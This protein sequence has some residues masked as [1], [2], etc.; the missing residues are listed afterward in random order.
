MLCVLGAS[1]HACAPHAPAPACARTSAVP[2]SAQ[3]FTA[4]RYAQ[5]RLKQSNTQT[6]TVYNAQRN[7]ASKLLCTDSFTKGAPMRLSSHSLSRWT[8][9]L[10]LAAL[11]H[12]AFAQIYIGQTSG[13]TGPS[14]ASVKELTDGARLYLDAVNA[15]GGVNGQKIELISLDDKFDPK[16]AAENSRKL[17]TEHNVL[18][19][20]LTRGTPHT[21]AVLP[22]LSEHQIA[23]IGPSSGAM[24]L[25]KPV[26]P[27]VF[28]VRATYQREA[29]HAVNHLS[30]IGLTRIGVIQV[31]DSFG[32]DAAEGA[33]LGF[34]RVGKKPVL[35]E[36]YNREKWD[37]TEIA[38]RVKAS[39]AQAV[40]FLGSG[41][42]VM[43]GIAAVRATGS[44]A[45]FVTLS[46]NASR[47]FVKGLKENARGT[48]IT[49]VFPYERSFAAPMVKE[50]IELAAAR[51]ASEVTP[52]M[53]EG[54]A[55]AKVLVAALR[56]AGPA[57]NRRKVQQALNGM[58]KYNLGGLEVDFSP[59][60]HTGLDFVDLSI[61]GPN[62]KLIR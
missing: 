50:A 14:E 16:L 32:N 6:A 29:S 62:G 9:W 43:D 33:R 19:L 36:R 17:I 10:M 57:P 52:A 4:L 35:H 27:W 51:D 46:N 11:P 21:Q 41:K 26:N 55:A 44:A 60:D 37:F 31:D 42:A 34:E 13:F 49:Q 20:F 24:L 28:N 56:M 2:A 7:P 23:L 8:A 15:R 12:L 61:V 39:E 54:F 48:I 58:H 38:R 3:H 40:L 25:H 47:G 18:A 45:Q 30:T 53:L 5:S 59:T 22:L 1:P